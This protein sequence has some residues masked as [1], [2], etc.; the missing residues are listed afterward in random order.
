MFSRQKEI[1]IDYISISF[2]CWTNHSISGTIHK[3]Y[4]N[5]DT[6]DNVI[7]NS[8]TCNL[9]GKEFMSACSMLTHHTLFAL[10]QF[11]LLSV[12]RLVYLKTRVRNTRHLCIEFCVT[13][14]VSSDRQKNKHFTASVAPWASEQIRVSFLSLKH[15]HIPGP[16]DRGCVFAPSNGDF[17][18]DQALHP[19][20]PCPNGL[21]AWEPWVP[22]QP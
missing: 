5:W 4:P 19:N 17:Q 2:Q 15:T 3:I 7:L 11:S 6:E 10:C 1:K 12:T 22:L 8:D 18:N 9:Q 13:P 16:T 20:R 14:S 21:S